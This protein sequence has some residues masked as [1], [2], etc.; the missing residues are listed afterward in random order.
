M[1]GLKERVKYLFTDTRGLILLNIGILSIIIAIFGTLSG[2]LKDWG[3]AKLTIKFLKMNILPHEREGRIII[4]YH[5]IAITFVTLLTYIITHVVKMKENQVKNIRNTITTG[6]LLIV[7]FGL[8]F[9]YWGHN[10]VFHGLF[11]VGQTLVFFAGV[12]LTVA[13]WPWNKDYYNTQ[14]EYAHSKKGMPYER[15]AFFT[16]AAATLGSAV[17]GAVAG[18]HWG[19][20][21]ETFLS[22]DAIRH[23]HHSSLQLAIVGHLHIMLAL[24]CVATA[25]VIGRW[26]DWKGILHKIG[27]PFFIV[28][29]IVMTMGVWLLIPFRPIAHKI[30]YV[31]S[32]FVMLGALMLVIFGW[33]KLIKEGTSSI[34]KPSFF[35]K[36]GA[37]FKDPLKF[38]SLW[39]M[40][41]MNFCVSGVGI[42]M[43]IKLTTLMRVIPLREERITLTGHWHILATLTATIVLFYIMSEIFPLKG[44]V[45]KIFGWSIILGSDVAFAMVTIFSLKRLWVQEETQQPMVDFL[46]LFTEIGLATLLLILGIYMIW[47]LVKFIRKQIEGL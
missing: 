6:Y 36:L 33:S 29:T 9:A 37:L 35:Q 20:G 21:H 14:T 38:G 24:V 12:Q 10:W 8:G 5:T 39:Q 40:V 45:R 17:F 43:A 46:M 1:N 42:F 13:L 2:P 25:L 31:G 30:I 23:V 16:M 18:S 32:F 34:E 41:F 27:T 3:V 28:G 7:F 44:K 19:Q 47:L 26:F 4:L 11:I 15:A 22:E